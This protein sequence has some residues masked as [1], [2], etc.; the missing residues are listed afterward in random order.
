MDSLFFFGGLTSNIIIDAALGFN[1]NLIFFL[2]SLRNFQVHICSNRS[3]YISCSDNTPICVVKAFIHLS[4]RAFW[5]FCLY[6]EW[7]ESRCDQ[8]SPS[9]ERAKA[10]CIFYN[11]VLWSRVLSF[12]DGTCDVRCLYYGSSRLHL[13][14]LKPPK[15]INK[16]RVL[17]FLT[18]YLLSRPLRYTL[19]LEDR[20]KR[21]KLQA[22]IER[23]TFYRI[24]FRGVCVG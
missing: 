1:F 23:F 12:P 13:G 19:V 9:S 17:H 8:I 24:W 22:E 20:D 10:M 6:P 7:N 4:V 5:S 11:G 16:V 15:M 18:C 2:K 14:L 21:D 3:F